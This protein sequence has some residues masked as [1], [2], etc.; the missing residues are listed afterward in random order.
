M[1]INTKKLSCVVTCM[2]LTDNNK[3]Q[4]LVIAK[5]LNDNQNVFRAILIK[6]NMKNISCKKKKKDIGIM[7]M[8]LVSSNLNHIW[9]GV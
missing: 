6:Q 1:L 8:D 3:K 4:C 5:L 9:P 7:I 2:N